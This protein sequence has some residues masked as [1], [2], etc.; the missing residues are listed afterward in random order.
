MNSN[1]LKTLKQ[2]YG[3]VGRHPQLLLTLL[4]IIVIPFAFLFS[5]QQ[6]LRAGENNQERLE[7][8]RLGMLHD[9]FS[10]LLRASSFDTSRVQDEITNIST[11]NPD[12]IEFSVAKD[13]GGVITVFA[14][15]NTEQINAPVQDP[16]AY[17][18]SII[19]PNESI[20]TPH[21]ES[22]IRY[23]K[24]YRLV[25]HDSS[26]Y[27]I[28]TKTSLEH[29]D[30]LF[31]SRVREAYYILFAI[32]L[33]V[34][35]LT[36]HHVRMIDYAYLYAQVK[37]ANDTKDLFTNTVAHE[38]RAPLTAI[39]GLASMISESKD[40]STE[41]LRNAKN[42]DLAAS[43]LVTIVGDLLD[44]ARIQSGQLIIEKQ[45]IDVQMTIN[46]VIDTMQSQANEKHIALK[47]EGTTGQFFVTTDPKRLHQ[48]LTN[49]VSNAIKYTPSGSI[50][51]AI[52]DIGQNVELR[53]KDTGMGISAD[54]QK[55]LFTPFFRVKRQEVSTIVGTGLGMF[56]T[57][58]LIERLG[59]SI[60]I[61]SIK[62]IGTHVVIVLPK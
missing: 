26:P 37:E 40:V 16:H 51:I 56:I 21:A 52:A 43:R 61:E 57:K 9:V 27:Y 30:T 6:F 23:W 41:N 3:Y 19:H 4:L 14:S 12:I 39:R 53:I 35:L 44:V 42:I 22:G 60:G 58:Q 7:K 62:G 20:I 47:Q 31:A 1:L 2:G 18:M 34:L 15:K 48:A 8:D 25:S 54:N 55:N 38:L 17:R 59:G 5:A 28:Y 29:I 32:L 10:S 24:S 36:I 33:V 45:Q 46:S 11:L 49:V 13:V 50:T